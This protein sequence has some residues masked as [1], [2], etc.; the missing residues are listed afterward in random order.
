MILFRSITIIYIL[1]F[2][3]IGAGIMP[4][5]TVT[6]IVPL[7]V[8]PLRRRLTILMTTTLLSSN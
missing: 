4:N 5:L 1:Y 6:A 2:Y 3:L 8:H 7:Y